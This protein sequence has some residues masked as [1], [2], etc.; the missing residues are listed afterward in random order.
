MIQVQSILGN[1]M[2]YVS[3]SDSGRFHLVFFSFGQVIN[4]SCFL[5]F[6][7]SANDTMESDTFGNFLGEKTHLLG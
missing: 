2:S 7:C 1:L 3:E 6:L 4:N 5:L